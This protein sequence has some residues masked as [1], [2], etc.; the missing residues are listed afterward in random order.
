M[1]CWALLN[2]ESNRLIPRARRLRRTTD[3]KVVRDGARPTGAGP[4]QVTAFAREP[5]GSVSCARFGI[6]VSRRVGNAVIR[7]LVRRRLRAALAP[8]VPR[9]S[10]KWDIVIGTRPAAAITPYEQLASALEVSFHRAGVIVHAPAKL[11][12]A[13]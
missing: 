10:D 13:P 1:L 2:S 8:L 4:I 12:P 5:S 7:N 11:N 9:V 6:V 3:F